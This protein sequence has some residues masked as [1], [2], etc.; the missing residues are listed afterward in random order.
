MQ[1][2]NFHG[3]TIAI[4]TRQTYTA[5]VMGALEGTTRTQVITINPEYVVLSRNQAKLKQLTTAPTIA[6]PDGIGLT[7]ALAARGHN[8]ER[9]PGSEMIV[10]ICDYARD[11]KLN[12][13]IVIPQNSLSS[14]DEITRA[15]Q[16]KYP[17]I[18]CLVLV[19][20][21]IRID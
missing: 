15:L 1:Y 3:H 9:Y 17:G 16:A 12:I 10:D 14:R 21:A 2:E 5:A 18:K 13:G 11:H 20:L 7:W 8:V 6:I 4:G 19:H